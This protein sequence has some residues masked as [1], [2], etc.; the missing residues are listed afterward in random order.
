MI[1]RSIALWAAAAPVRRVKR[2][3]SSGSAMR[4]R[5]KRIV[6]RA[7]S[8]VRREDGVPRSG[9]YIKARA[10]YTGIAQALPR[11][12]QGTGSAG[13][14]GGVRARDAACGD[15]SRRGG[16]FKVDREGLVR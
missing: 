10:I 6:R 12:A 2:Q 1:S 4:R 8:S 14:F 9:L 13:G 7:T 11:A 3:S 15:L 5:L 16:E